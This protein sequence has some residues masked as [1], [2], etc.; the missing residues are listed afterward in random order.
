MG[1]LFASKKQCEAEEKPDVKENLTSFGSNLW[2]TFLLVVIWVYLYSVIFGAFGLGRL[3]RGGIS[4]SLM[5][6]SFV[7]AAFLAYTAALL[8]WDHVLPKIKDSYKFGGVASFTF[9][10]FV[11]L[12]L[13]A[14]CIFMYYAATFWWGAPF[15]IR[16]VAPIMGII[17][18]VGFIGKVMMGD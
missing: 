6:F 5:T 9:F 17:F 15:S 11:L 3:I 4:P 18:F 2:Q 13:V 10:A 7:V 8:I 16:I 14:F 12:G 1:K